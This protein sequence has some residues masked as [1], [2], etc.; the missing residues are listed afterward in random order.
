MSVPGQHPGQSP[1]PDQPPLDRSQLSRR[2]ILSAGVLG[3]AVLASVAALRHGDP[4]A[5][6][7]VVPA[8]TEP[9]MAA[10]AKRAALADE[11]ARSYDFNQ[12][13]LF[14]GVYAAGSQDPGFDDTTFSE[15]T[16]P[17]T[18]TPLSWA[19][20]D[21]ATWQNVW[22]YRKHFLGSQ[23]GGGRV[24]VDFDGVMTN[25]TVVL[26]GTTVAAH[27]GG[28]LPW[29]TELT[30]ALAAGDNV[31]AVVVDSRWLDVPPG[32]SPRGAAAVDY[33]QPGG[34][35]RD[36][37]LRVV[38]EVFL[39]D[40]FARP[41]RVLTAARGVEVQATIDAAAVPSGPVRITAEL[42]D[43]SRRL[44]TASTTVTITSPG[45]T[46]AQLSLTGVGE[47]V[48]WS[49]DT[50]RL[51]TVRTHLV[52][53]HGQPHA[54]DVAIG[55]REAV[56]RPD[57]FY[58]NGERFQIFG[59]D[60]HQLFPYLGMAAGQRLQ[61]RDAEIL[62][63]E[64]SCNMV[65]CSH[66][67]QSPH[68]LDACDELGL[69]VWEEP[70][71][72]QYIGA[73]AFQEIVLQNVRDMVIRDRNRPSV[74]LWGTR[75]NESANEVRLYQQTRQIADELDG[76][77]QTSGAMDIHSRADWAQDVFAFDDYHTSDGKAT[78]RPPL[79]GVPY[80]VTEA[81]GALDG[82]PLYR[83]ID[84]ASV[85]AEQGRMHAQVH[86]IAQSDPGYAGLLGWC[87]V[88]YASLNGGDRIW[89]S[90]KWPGVLDTFRVPKPGAAFYRSQADPAAGPVI[91]P[92][93]F[94]DFGPGSPDGPGPG[95]M[96]ATNCER[97]A[98]Y[99]AGKHVATGSPDR[100]RY[101]GLAHPLVLADLTAD[102]ASRPE[103]RIDGFIGTARVATAVMS[104]DTSRDRLVLTPDHT[105]IQG[106]GADATRLTFRALDAYGHQRPYVT[107]TVALGLT[108]PATLVGDSPFAFGEFGGVGGAFV[109]SQPGRTG[110]VT[111]TAR[112][113][114]LGQAVARVSVGRPDAGRRFA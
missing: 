65:R 74:I 49:P 97:L 77:R 90:L 103:L 86:S 18:V 95:A 51:Y 89:R 35:Y 52:T 91:L 25:A 59:L 4:Q 37:T 9:R 11:A 61:R 54:L 106:D 5:G 43:G 28:Y 87:A 66:Y 6:P 1:R 27:E 12:G 80:L 8:G 93:F 98:I 36:A 110:L 60:R 38:P 44:A 101:P 67:P 70:P 53:P 41:A 113:V 10:V 32:G 83:W 94:W 22:I 30:G 21:P 85:L 31:L 100:K 45:T 40:V 114:S 99:V 102:G 20:W 107:G 7:P 88:D 42:L 48:L 64:L 68:F 56:F 82:P 3:G 69:L 111:V 39:G 96:I 112:H 71:G 78:L 81:V 92:M 109:R 34:I 108:G 23:V 29:S 75:L 16:L 55:F 57:G 63:N 58:L 73:A 104:A 13:W 2:A 17:H 50:P 26:N 33:L 79:A 46:V 76:S 72:W 84:P 62:K 105:S 15:V 47:V 24:F 19:D 14:G